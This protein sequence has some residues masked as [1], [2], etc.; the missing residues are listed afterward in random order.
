MEYIDSFRASFETIFLIMAAVG[1]LL[2]SWLRH[3]RKFERTQSEY[4]AV[5]NAASEG[6]L[7]SME[8]VSWFQQQLIAQMREKDDLKEALEELSATVKKQVEKN[9]ELETKVLGLEN[10]IQDLKI[11]LLH[12]RTERD[13]YIAVIDRLG[14]QFVVGEETLSESQIT[15]KKKEEGE[16]EDG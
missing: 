13:A 11:Q 4:D 7:N 14:V 3:N 5:Q 15:I 1:G 16:K 8:P 2:Y 12:T 9:N 6:N 10:Q